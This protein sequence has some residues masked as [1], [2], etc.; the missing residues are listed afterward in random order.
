M[1]SNKFEQLGLSTFYHAIPTIAN[2]NDWSQWNP[3]VKVFI[4]IYPV[5]K[6]EAIPPLEEEEVQQLSHCQTFYSAMIA[7]KLNHNAA[8]RI[9]A[10]EIT[11]VQLL[12]KV[13]EEHFKPQGPGTYLNL[14][15]TYMSLTRAK[16]GSA[17][18]LGAEIRKIH[19]KKL[20]FDPACVTPEIDLPCHYPGGLWSTI[21]GILTYGAQ[22]S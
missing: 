3:K 14:Q 7:A 8:Q 13:V 17:Q 19:A 6:D 5:A 16:C 15:R 10:F 20:L 12:I 1:D 4:H 18:A 22:I 2:P 9:N 21:T 11:R